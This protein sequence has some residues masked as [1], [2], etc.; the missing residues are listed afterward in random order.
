MTPTASTALRCSP[1]TRS[2]GVDPIG[3]APN[4]TSFLVVEVPLPWPRDV[5]AIDELA[6]VRAAAKA[7][8]REGRR[9]RLQAIVP[10]DA[11]G[12]ARVIAY[13][14]PDHPFDGYLRREV[15]AE[16]SEV[17]DAAVALIEGPAGDGSAPTVDDGADLLVCTH[18]RRDACCGSSGTALWHE[19][20]DRPDVMGATALRR[21]SHTGGH[22]FAPTAIH[23]PT[24]TVWAWLDVDRVGRMLARDEP[25][26]DLLDF[27]RGSTAMAST[28]EQVVE[29]AIF[30]EVGW[31]WLDDRRESRI[32]ESA[33]DR[34]VVEIDQWTGAGARATWRG[35]T[36]VRGSSPVPDCGAPLDE[37][38]KTAPVVELV[39]G[40]LSWERR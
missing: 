11:N 39:E 40:S 1:A 3:S 6:P 12:A 34:T 26:G 16:A 7:A 18:G 19:L 37:A 28:A 30:A 14:L 23:L 31:S 24:G 29:R 36:V 4:R 20:T 2:L 25:V 10:H 32:V 17:V 8:K 27:Y 38:H 35:E 22:R 5:K 9:W 21:T 13:S 33:G 15:E